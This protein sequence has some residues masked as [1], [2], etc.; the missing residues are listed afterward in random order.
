M[1]LIF[2]YGYPGT[3]KLTVAKELAK[4]TNFS[5]FHNHLTVDLVESLFVFGTKPFIEMREKIWL[6]SFKAA[7]RYRLSGLIFTF[8]FEKSVSKKF[9]QNVNKIF[10]KKGGV[11][12]VELSCSTKELERR[13]RNP[14]R[15]KYGKM[16]S[17]TKL[18]KFSKK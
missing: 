13:I 16:S 9:I 18:K 17:V 10:H 7:I 6:E 4:L 8:A 11:Y 14:I 15:K 2:I 5:I 1:K 3:G 12:F